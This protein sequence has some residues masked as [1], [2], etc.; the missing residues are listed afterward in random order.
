MSPPLARPR[1]VVVTG[2]ARRGQ[3]GE[4]VAEAFAAMGDTVCVVARDIRDAT[5]RAGD[6]TARGFD[7]R[8]FAC[9][10]A[11]AVATVELARVVV[12][13]AGRVDALVNLA[14]GFDVSGPVADADPEVFARQYRINVAT[15]LM[16]TRAFLPALRQAQGAIVY[17]ASHSALPGARARRVSAYVMAKSA[18]L[19][20][21]R[22]VAQEEAVHKVRA[23]AIA[24]T[25]IRTLTNTES[26][27][28]DTRYVERETV[29]A[30]ITWLCSA[31]AS[32]V[33]GQV[34]E[35]A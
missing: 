11:D 20:L 4:A 12:A 5:A 6:L 35:L 15:A 31:S 2:V 30:T 23:N 21:M 19:A 34:L 26:M 22:V 7:V 25:A 3:V 13:S 33:S 10:L 14:G 9:D 24:P 18:V 27:K 28:S 1:C 8:P 16:T 32:A 29:A 17:A